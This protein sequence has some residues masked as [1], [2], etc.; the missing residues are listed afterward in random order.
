M[1]YT[2]R[3]SQS[4]ID[5]KAIRYCL[6]NPES[7][8]DL[9]PFC[10]PDP[11]PFIYPDSITNLDPDPITIFYAY[12]LNHVSASTNNPAHNRRDGKPWAG[13]G[14]IRGSRRYWIGYR[15]LPGGN[16]AEAE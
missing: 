13:F 4:D 15:W 6:P 8:P 3:K 10:Y 11:V 14:L 1:G 9:L 2:R 12:P 7:D 5:T 16:I